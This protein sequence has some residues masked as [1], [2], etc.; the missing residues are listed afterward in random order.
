MANRIDDRIES[1]AHIRQTAERISGRLDFSVRE[2]ALAGNRG[3]TIAASRRCISAQSCKWIQSA[4]QTRD[5]GRALRESGVW[6]LP[7][8]IRHEENSITAT[9]HHLVEQLVS[10]SDTRRKILERSVI[11]AAIA[12]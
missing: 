5:P 12:A 11:Q 7:V 8:I 2:C 4:V 6:T 9:Q 3:C 1:K 10:G